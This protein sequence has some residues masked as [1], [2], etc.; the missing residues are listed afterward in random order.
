M[1]L[2]SD[3]MALPRIRLVCYKL[4]LNQNTLTV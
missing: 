4:W 1:P 3:R 2:Q